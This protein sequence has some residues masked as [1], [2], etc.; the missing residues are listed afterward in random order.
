MLSLNPISVFPSSNCDSS[1]VQIQLLNQFFF[2]FRSI[3]SHSDSGSDSISGHASGSNSDSV[4][5]SLV[6]SRIA[7]R[8]RLPC[9]P[10][11]LVL[12]SHLSRGGHGDDD[13]IGLLCGGH[14]GV[15]AVVVGV[16]E[17]AVNAPPLPS[18]KVAGRWGK[19][20]VVRLPPLWLIN[21]SRTPTSSCRT[22]T[23][24]ESVGGGGGCQL[25]RFLGTLLWA[26]KH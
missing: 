25:A 5:E 10:V 16:D 14:A 22:P 3:G 7:S 23:N 24:L 18:L 21:Y 12:F 17:W 15:V 19:E 11:L 4:F 8:Y 1:S 6:E 2:W 26:L 13:D 9:S 20:L